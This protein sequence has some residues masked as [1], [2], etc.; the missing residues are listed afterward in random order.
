MQIKDDMRSFL[1]LVFYAVLFTE[2][3]VK[4]VSHATWFVENPSRRTLY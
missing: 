3:S 4:S 2:C 1:A